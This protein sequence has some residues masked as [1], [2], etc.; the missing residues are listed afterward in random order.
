MLFGPIRALYSAKFYLK[1]LLKSAWRAFFFVVY[2]LVLTTLFSSIAMYIF[3]APRITQA[4]DTMIDYLPEMSITN[5]ILVVNNNQPLTIEPAGIGNYNLVFDTGRTEPVYPTE[6]RNNNTAMLI[7][8]D[9]VYAALDDRF[10]ETPIPADLN[11][12][13]TRETLNESKE[14]VA[15][16][17]MGAIIFFMFMSQFIRIPLMVL[18]AFLVLLIL[19]N[20]MRAETK[21][22][23]IFKLACYVQAPAM[24]VYIISFFMPMPSFIVGLG[25]LAVFVIYGQIIFNAQKIG[26]S[27]EDMMGYPGHKEETEETEEAEETPALE[28]QENKNDS[29]NN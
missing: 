18:L 25:Y 11:L 23:D 19:A 29:E 2:V 12:E 8:S 15:N 10:Q 6:M 7:T 3:M 16:I 24:L 5:G 17:A 1:R 21:K 28:E 14:P 27:E 20:A 13:L 4:V 26:L 22:G 9:T